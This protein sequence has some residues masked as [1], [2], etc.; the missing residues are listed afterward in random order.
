MS[1]NLAQLDPNYVVAFEYSKENVAQLV[2]EFAANGLP[3]V[4]RP[5]H[6]SKTV[7]A[8]TR[9]EEPGVFE[10]G[11]AF[12]EKH[13]KRREQQQQQQQQHHA[14]GDGAQEQPWD[15]SLHPAQQAQQA[16]QNA[17]VK[18]IAPESLM[19]SAGVDTTSGG[20]GE[21]AEN[22][23]GKKAGFVNR[24]KDGL[25]D[26]D[27]DAVVKGGKQVLNNNKSGLMSAG[28]K[29][30]QGD[31]SQL[32]GQGKKVATDA[33]NQ[34]DKD[35]AL[36]TGK[37]LFSGDKKNIIKDGKK[38]VVKNQLENKG[39]HAL[40]SGGSAT[41]Q[42]EESKEVA[43][44]TGRDYLDKKYGAS[45]ASG[46]ADTSG[47]VGNEKRSANDTLGAA[48]P[49]Q[50]ST[51]GGGRATLFAIVANLDFVQSVTPIYDIEKRKK[52]ESTVNRLVQTVSL[53]ATDHDL[54]NLEHL[55]RNPREILYFF[56]FKN[57]IRWLMPISLVGVLCRLF[58]R[59]TSPW[60]FNITYTVLLIS[61]ALLYTG[62]WVYYYEP[63]YANRLGKVL[64]VVATTHKKLNPPYV[65]LY[66]KFCFIP[67]A[68]LFALSVVAFQFL[69]FFIEIFITQLYS[70]PFSG[71]LA[72]LP[73]VLIS[74]F[75]PIIT[76]VYNKFFVDP[77]VAWEN[78]PDPKKSKSEKNYVLTFLTS[79]VP[80]FITLF[81]YLPLG[82]KFTPSMRQTISS[83]AGKVHIPVAASQFIVDLN[84]YKKQIFF[85]TVT[86]QI[87]NMVVENFLPFIL[88]ALLPDFVKDG[89]RSVREVNS[90]IDSMVHSRYPQD[91]HLWKK[92]QSLHASNYGEF[93]E[94]A[95]Y[96]KLVVQFGYIAM[97]SIIWPLAPFIFAIFDLII[98][99]AD[100]WR[101]FIKCKPSSNPTDL[102]VSKGGAHKTHVSSAPWDG[103]LEKITYLGS[104]VSVTLLLMYRY[105]GFPGVGLTT[106]LEK[107]GSWYTESPLVLSWSKILL[108]AAAVEHLVL[109]GYIYLK[110]M[111]ISYQI[112][113]EPVTLPAVKSQN[114]SYNKEVD[115]TAAIMEEVSYAPE[116]KKNDQASNEKHDGGVSG[117]NAAE[118]HAASPYEKDFNSGHGE[119]QEY[120]AY[121]GSTP[122]ET[123]A[124]T[125]G[126]IDGFR[127]GIAD[128][129]EQTHG[130]KLQGVSR[131]VGK[132]ELLGNEAVASGMSRKP[133]SSTHKVDDSVNG[134]SRNRSTKR[135]STHGV[136]DAK[137][138]KD[139]RHHH[140][141]TKE[142][143]TSVHGDGKGST[144]PFIVT[145]SQSREIPV[146]SQSEK[147]LNAHHAVDS[148]I[149]GGIAGAGVGGATSAAAASGLAESN[150]T[151][152]R[153]NRESSYVESLTPDDDAGATLP[154]TIPTSKN[155]TSRFDKNGRPI[156]S[157][158]SDASTSG[159][160]PTTPGIASTGDDAI[161]VSSTA[162]GLGAAVGAPGDKKS[163]K[164]SKGTDYNRTS[165][166]GAGGNQHSKSPS[167]LKGGV[168][169]DSAQQDP[170]SSKDVSSNPSAMKT[171]DPAAS[172][173][174]AGDASQN[175]S[176]APVEGVK[177]AKQDAPVASTVFSGSSKG[178][179]GDVGSRTI[180]PTTGA[181]RT[182]HGKHNSHGVSEDSAGVAKN[183]HGKH[184][185]HEVFG[186]AS[187]AE[188]SS[189]GKKTAQNTTNDVN[190]G[191]GDQE[192]EHK[193]NG[194][195]GK[196]PSGAASQAQDIEKVTQ[197]KAA[198]PE[199]PAAQQFGRDV[200][201][202]KSAKTFGTAESKI[203]NLT[204]ATKP[205]EASR[206]ATDATNATSGSAAAGADGSA[207]VASSNAR[208]TPGRSATKS[209]ADT[210][211]SKAS[212]SK[213]GTPS[214]SKTIGHSSQSKGAATQSKS[215][216]TGDAQKN[217]AS[218][219]P[220]S[221][222][223]NPELTSK[224]ANNASES[225]TKH[226]S[227]FLHKIIKKLE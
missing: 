78:G 18:S 71:I 136:A 34:L 166:Q 65:V 175:R 134:I 224:Q 5:G 90:D 46:A 121:D 197:T 37:K 4:T 226:K 150:R 86:A 79:Y 167:G 43:L 26:V 88:D 72:L 114:A 81:V 94:D 89:E 103:I 21:Q 19:Q 31:N 105:S 54:I 39:K 130:D 49:A 76:A 227:G 153:S 208:K 154:E 186:D 11:E 177:S 151:S 60:E 142:S 64:N 2:S 84:R 59:S 56:Y 53:T 111:L 162:G 139:S 61:W 58:S 44:D 207:E 215:S 8:F 38:A 140:I 108:V 29:V 23:G 98:F 97:F 205:S 189:N 179:P 27:K 194:T 202:F 213:S 24:V 170:N 63:M 185:S 146:Q 120:N 118:H 96:S 184:S 145:D 190:V 183:S 67:V 112:Q 12:T 7:Y 216:A 82:H 182:S 148:E 165:R 102:Q 219:G 104:V 147:D 50:N 209:K 35:Q 210:P 16:Q 70:G 42:P 45:G 196:L 143:N 222:S 125:S 13:G 211:R 124:R 73:T 80:L 137:P 221:R 152:S 149:N 217:S 192:V 198:D 41:E 99:R 181:K 123:Y 93:D 106:A 176:T 77:M 225:K 169:G 14:A 223:S 20:A 174:P 171:L 1:E 212:N 69:C 178:A 158:V 191:R 74:A 117:S 101:A 200:H 119:K 109:L 141:S 25:N 188:K 55:T 85:Y 92:V 9:I 156:K 75:V 116:S 218:K 48:G 57:Y 133:S 127:A 22:S 168:E 155:Y 159:D 193:I 220:K 132:H 15:P 199:S 161:A 214:R 95:N 62:S 100:L 40:S 47:Y 66:K 68:I 126:Y 180:E 87:I 173:N 164:V 131:S 30:A 28:Q 3:T 204:G 83:Y 32:Q 107:R 206:G 129:Q 187:E 195:H 172:A 163:S 135:S 128:G 51:T 122:E 17:S 33:A 144:P 110:D 115:E 201:S 157:A 91:Y 52:L 113:F 6:N 160:S 10:S 138:S 203:D 36:E